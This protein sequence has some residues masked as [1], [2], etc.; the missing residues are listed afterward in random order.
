MRIYIAFVLLLVL[1]L[2]MA[3]SATHL[4]GGEITIKQT[5]CGSLQYEITLTIYTNLAQEV[6]A[7]SGVLSFGDG[8]SITTPSLDNTIVDPRF[9]VGKAVFKISHT[10]AKA[11]TYLITYR[12]PNRNNGIL[13]IANSSDAPFF[14]EAQ[15]NILS[16]ICNNPL[17]FEILPIDRACMGI[18][19]SHNPGAVD[20]D[21]D[22]ISYEIAIPKI[23]QG[24]DAQGYLFPNDRKFYSGFNYQTA[25]EDQT[26][27]PIF[28]IDTS[29]GQVTW[30]APGAA[31]E[32]AMALKVIEWRKIDGVWINLGYTIRDMQI[33][34]E[35]CKNTRPFLDLPADV[36]VSPGTKISELIRGF[37]TEFDQVKIEVFFADIFSSMPTISHSNIF[38]STKPPYDTANIKFDWPIACD[39]V[40]D[41]P[42]RIVFKVTDDP[43]NGI[44][45]ATFKTW[46]I[47]VIGNAPTIK[48]ETL[49]LAVKS[50]KLVW[51][52][53]ECSAVKS[54]EIWRKVGKETNTLNECVRGVLKSLGYEKIG[55]SDRDYFID[56]NINP[57]ASY[58]YRLVTLFESPFK[59][60]SRASMQFCFGPIKVDAPT[61][62][63]VSVDK[64]DK[65]NGEIA[66]RWTSPFQIDKSQ[67]PPPY[68]YE[69]FRT[70][71][72]GDFNKIT[73]APIKDTVWIDRQLNT[74]ENS[75]GYKVV[76]YSPNGLTK[77]NPVDT[78]ALSF[79]P[80][81]EYE[82]RKN[83][84]YLTWDARVPWSN[85]N[86]R[87][88]YHFIY[89]KEYRSTSFILIDSILTGNV[90]LESGFD[91]LDK[92]QYKNL[93]LVPNTLYE[94][95]IS[96]IGTYDNPLILE[97]LVNFSNELKAQLIDDAPPCSP[98]VT[99][100]HISCEDFINN[101]PCSIVE[102]KNVLLWTY[103]DGCGN[104]VKYFKIKYQNSVLDEPIELSQL[105]EFTFVDLKKN[106][107]AGCYQVV[108]VD[109]SGNE[110]EPSVLE[111]VDNCP[112]IFIPNI[113][114]ANEDGFND[115]FPGFAKRAN[116]EFSKCPRFVENINVRIFN[117]WGQEVYALEKDNSGVDLLDEWSGKDNKGNELSTG[118]YFY[119]AE[120]IFDM[121]DPSLRK[122]KSTG[123]IN[124]FR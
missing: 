94:Y 98:I 116:V 28:G 120:I 20:L 82:A 64:T 100:S 115:V 78:G 35:D 31:G 89:R 92:G 5:Q 9:N 99:V 101:A 22:S 103:P 10:F 81:L 14:I 107:F 42:Y 97:P 37:D 7:G 67:F 73:H 74:I 29:T 71:S 68:T 83:G 77:E 17:S 3:S 18:S 19:F 55:V 111:C 110:S 123:W 11:G 2:P 58:C 40:R 80:R 76:V 33:L 1:V 30:D 34:V 24:L 106:S 12:E 15:L 6:S 108:A 102:Y 88:P 48:N 56:K 46:S 86:E 25:T 91:Y 72:N 13:N 8:F 121:L 45:L 32:Y 60:R 36:C 23:N 59:S 70:A 43:P 112:S 53:Y 41:Q 84:I 39:M 104:D 16:G 117:R 65:A 38:Q 4:R 54:M 26:S 95:K 90:E 75:Y 114:T 87:F 51:N 61:M 44:R 109:Y 105:S 118:V 21:K 119:E 69:V 50:L 57:G 122:Q 79:Y 52:M 47:S 49:D 93:P 96:T 124:L 66:L 62:I 113:L 85:Q 27:T 63:N